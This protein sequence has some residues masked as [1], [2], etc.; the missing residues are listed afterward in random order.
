MPRAGIDGRFAR[1]TM[2]A[3]LACVLPTAV[4]QPAAS[5]PYLPS[6]PNFSSVIDS[7]A[8]VGAAAVSEV[9]ESET[10][11]HLPD[12]YGVG[13]AAHDATHP[14]VLPACN[15][16]AAPAWCNRPWCFVLSHAC[17]LDHVVEVVQPYL[18][19]DLSRSF[20]ACGHVRHTAGQSGADLLV[21]QRPLRVFS[22]NNTFGWMGSYLD[23]EGRPIAPLGMR[24]FLLGALDAAQIP[25]I[26]VDSLAPFPDSTTQA[27]L[28]IHD[29][30]HISSFTQCVAACGLGIVD[31]C[32]GI[33]G[34]TSTRIMLAPM[35]PPP[36]S[37]AEQLYVRIEPSDLS[38]SDEVRAIFQPFTTDL[39]L[40]ILL[41]LCTFAATFAFVVPTATANFCCSSRRIPSSSPVRATSSQFLNKHLYDSLFGCV[42]GECATVGRSDAKDCPF[43]LPT[44]KR[45]CRRRKA[46]EEPDGQ[47]LARA[48]N[49]PRLCDVC[50]DPSHQ[51]HRATDGVDE[52]R[53]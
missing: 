25:Y 33:F 28:E 17:Q 46:Q 32:V 42:A 35:L 24:N 41:A 48:G 15:V 8:C 29:Q 5:I 19:S 30:H 40:C 12:G 4:A 38:L 22:V 16:S 1:T 39:W 9:H 44:V 6:L 21:G 47:H 52:E 26:E 34:V 14:H 23:K 2:R 51:L 11:E 43:R 7:C 31:L 53:A 18:Y 45:W 37:F 27:A 36:A 50:D 13:C 10:G 20:A 49:Q 3:A